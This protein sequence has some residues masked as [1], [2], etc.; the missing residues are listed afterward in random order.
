MKFEPQIVCSLD[1][2]DG[3]SV[4]ES[5][6]HSFAF[7]WKEITEDL[8]LLSGP[9]VVPILFMGFGRVSTTDVLQV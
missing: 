6:A 3:C 7:R 4:W 9:A 5:L 2:R 8:I 1:A